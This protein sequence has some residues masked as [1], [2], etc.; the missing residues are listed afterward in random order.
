MD[1]L[2][3][4]I[5]INIIVTF[6][7][8]V[9]GAKKGL[10]S[11]ITQ[12]KEKPKT[13]LQSVPTA[14]ATVTL[15]ILIISLFN[16]GT[17]EYKDENLTLRLIAFIVYVAFSWIQILSFKTLGDNYS[18]DIVIYNK[19]KLVDK[20]LYKFIRHPQYISQVIIDLSASIAVLSYVLFPFFL[21]ELV[22]LIK[23]AN[24]E[25]KLLEK[26]FKSDFVEYKKKSG[27]MLPF[28]G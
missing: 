2:N 6:A 20:G 13:Y 11:A 3:I 14:V 21:I 8:N 18:Q 1:P 27:F 10:K 16:I 22:L 15:L 7:A 25:E 24:L 4:L 19:H 12:V 26:Y 9:S 17:L 28:I 5:A 23:R